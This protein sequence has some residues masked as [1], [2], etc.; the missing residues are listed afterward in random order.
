LIGYEIVQEGNI[1]RIGE[2]VSVA[3][4]EACNGLRMITAFIV[5]SGLV[6]MLVDRKWWEKLIVLISSIPIALLCNTIRLVVTAMFFTVLQGEFWE[7][8][9]HDFG[10][11]AMM[12]LAIAAIVGELWLLTK[13]TSLPVEE[14]AIV[15]TRQSH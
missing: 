3:V 10:G 4:L 15:I 11:Y 13:L 14:E 1:I 6:V 2:D 9:F 12:P 8:V 5:I 7:D